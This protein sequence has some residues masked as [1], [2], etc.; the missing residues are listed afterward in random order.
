MS[1]TESDPDTQF[2]DVVLAQCPLLARVLIKCAELKLSEPKIKDVLVKVADGLKPLPGL[3]RLSSHPAAPPAP[4]VAPPQAPPQAPHAAL[5]P[6]AQPDLDAAMSRLPQDRRNAFDT[7]SRDYNVPAADIVHGSIAQ[8]HLTERFPGGTDVPAGDI[9]AWFS[10]LPPEYQQSLLQLQRGQIAAGVHRPSADLPYPVA[11]THYPRFV[12]PAATPPAD[13]NQLLPAAQYRGLSDYA[14]SQNVNINDPVFHTWWLNQ[15]GRW[16]DPRTRP[17]DGVQSLIDQFTRYRGQRE[18]QQNIATGGGQA[19]V[20][21]GAVGAVSDILNEAT[22][23]SGDA[24]TLQRLLGFRRTA[25]GATQDHF[26]TRPYRQGDFRWSDFGRTVGDATGALVTA[27]AALV[28]DYFGSGDTQRAQQTNPGLSSTPMTSMTARS[29]ISPL[30][31][32]L[33]TDIGGDIESRPAGYNPGQRWGHLATTIGPDAGRSLFGRTGIANTPAQARQSGFTES[34]QLGMFPAWGAGAR[35]EAGQAANPVTRA[36][37]NTA[38]HVS[39]NAE[40]YLPLVALLGGGGRLATGQGW[41]RTGNTMSSLARGIAAAPLAHLASEP[42]RQIPVGGGQNLNDLL[43]DIAT[44]GRLD[45]TA[46]GASLGSRLWGHIREQAP[47]LADLPAMGAASGIGRVPGFSRVGTFGM[48]HPAALGLAP[49]YQVARNTIGGQ[50]SQQPERDAMTATLG[51]T[52]QQRQA[53]S[54]LQTLISANRNHYAQFGS[55]HP[56]LASQ[57]RSLLAADP[58]LSR[59]IGLSD[60]NP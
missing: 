59:V 38:A 46:P 26:V 12:F 24:P 20:Q 34:E 6:F 39:D 9:S 56:Q 4:P 14:A 49:G 5:R 47:M 23:G 40:N 27:P 2:A 11:G 28:S 52:A 33:N 54:L 60:D 57:I 18:A 51:L 37:L 21:H 3:P 29:L 16:A 58:S 44:R 7:F 35:M 19:A 45:A 13:P 1:S 30:N 42:V 53:V 25:P 17:V 41:A 15:A 48:P 31:Y 32:L 10:E 55:D 8:R 36:A 50:T 22:S 43:S